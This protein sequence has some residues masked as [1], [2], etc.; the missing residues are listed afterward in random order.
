LLVLS[1]GKKRLLLA[2][3][4]FHVASNCVAAATHTLILPPH[5]KY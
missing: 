2:C 3:N 4:L 1:N 5:S